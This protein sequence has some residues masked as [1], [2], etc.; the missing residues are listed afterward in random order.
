MIIAQLLC[1]I[2]AGGGGGGG[3]GAVYGP[4]TGLFVGGIPT[5]V[6]AGDAIAYDA[7]GATFT[8]KNGAWA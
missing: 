3:V 7:N 1:N 4:T 6:P 5:V 8:Y 2:S